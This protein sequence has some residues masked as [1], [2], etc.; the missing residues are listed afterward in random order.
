MTSN[1]LD[2][3]LC[4]DASIPFCDSIDIKINYKDT[5]IVTKRMKLDDLRNF[6]LNMVG[7][8]DIPIWKGCQAC[9]F[10]TFSVCDNNVLSQI[11]FSLKCDDKKVGTVALDQISLIQSEKLYCQGGAPRCDHGTESATYTT[12]TKKSQTII[13]AVISTLVVLI[14]GILVFI[15]VRNRV[16][17]QIPQYMKSSSQSEGLIRFPASFSD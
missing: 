16:N 3:Q 5:D 9:P 1:Y 7:C 11:Y 10:A 15:I 8:I 6:T 2:G 4:I 17:R 13:V 12:S 14:I